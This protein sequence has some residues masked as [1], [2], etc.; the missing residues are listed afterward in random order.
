MNSVG[1]HGSGMCVSH[2]PADSLLAGRSRLGHCAF[3]AGCPE[4]HTAWT[5]STSGVQALFLASSA[6][7]SIQ[8][9]ILVPTFEAVHLLSFLLA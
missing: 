7:L 4:F 2:P 9:H 6:L 8:N 5:F 3:D 1:G